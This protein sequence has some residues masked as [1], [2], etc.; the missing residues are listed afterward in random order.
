MASVPVTS[1]DAP[2][3]IA[4]PWSMAD[5]ARAVAL[6]IGATVLL[7]FSATQ[8]VRLFD[9]L[10]EMTALLSSAILEGLLLLAVWRFGPW[11]YGRSWRAL[12]LQATLH[13]GASLALLVF[14]GSIGF[15]I[16][17]SMVVTAVGLRDLAPPALP[18]ELMETYPQRI[19]AFFVIVL[20]APVAEEVFFRG[21]L[22]PVFVDRWR[23]LGGA[24]FVSLLFAISHAQPG[25]LIPAFV[26][27]MLFAW[28]YRRTGSLWNCCLAHGAQN[29]L[30]F[31]V[32]VST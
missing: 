1:T 32:V 21:F 10:K 31:A 23:F 11:R 6:V 29:A 18:S 4:V 16:L 20:A 7:I 13:N 30:A 24:A 5:A 3:S 26:S 17:Y 25:L 8:A 19:A 2:L 14:L 22:L 12:G 9:D 28:L 27:G 15:A